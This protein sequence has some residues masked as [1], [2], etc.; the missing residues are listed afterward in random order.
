MCV[1]IYIYHIAVLLMLVILPR[2]TF[3]RETKLSFRG[4]RFDPVAMDHVSGL[5]QTDW[6]TV[7]QPVQ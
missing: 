1:F 7:D 5:I 2:A 6:S 3:T 4:N